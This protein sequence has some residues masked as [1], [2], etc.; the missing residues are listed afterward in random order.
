MLTCA[1]HLRRRFGKVQGPTASD[2]WRH[3][4]QRIGVKLYRIVTLKACRPRMQQ[5]RLANGGRAG[6]HAQQGQ[7]DQK[8]WDS[9]HS[10]CL[11]EE[12]KSIL[13]RGGIVVAKAQGLQPL[14]FEYG[15]SRK[16]VHRTAASTIN[17]AHRGRRPQSKP[18]ATKNAKRHE[19]D[20]GCKTRLSCRFFLLVTFCGYLQQAKIGT[21]SNA[22]LLYGRKI[23]SSTALPCLGVISTA[24]A[25]AGNRHVSPHKS[26][27][28]AGSP[29]TATLPSSSASK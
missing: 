20:G 2:F 4:V 15:G 7:Q 10:D 29:S 27:P 16:T 12:S 18:I 14:D 6:G 3:V 26:P 8:E 19:K 21:V 23:S 9:N 17:M 11:P 25:A 28:L 5:T 1:C 13:W 24:P 22:M